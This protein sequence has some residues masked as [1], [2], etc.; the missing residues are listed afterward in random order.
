MCGTPRTHGGMPRHVVTERMPYVML[1]RQSQADMERFLIQPEVQTQV[2]H[3]QYPHNSLLQ[4]P[5]WMHLQCQHG[6][7][8]HQLLPDLDGSCQTSTAHPRYARKST[9]ADVD[10]REEGHQ[11]PDLH[12]LACLPA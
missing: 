4:I 3:P 2:Q 10:Q 5:P 6:G 11:N 8:V 12:E 1:R 7:S 9:N